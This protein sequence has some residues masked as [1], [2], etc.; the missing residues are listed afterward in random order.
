MEKYLSARDENILSKISQELFV[1]W[2]QVGMDRRHQLI[3]VVNGAAAKNFLRLRVAPPFPQPSESERQ[4]V[5]R[6]DLRMLS[7]SSRQ[8]SAIRKNHRPE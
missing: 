8:V 6:F 7:C 4:I 3:G 2:R 1:I 5:R